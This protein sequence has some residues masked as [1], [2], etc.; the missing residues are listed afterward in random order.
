MGPVEI[1]LLA[2]AGLITSMLSA[3]VGMAG[4]MTLLAVMLLFLDPLVAVP[5]HGV[6]QLVSNGTRTAVHRRSLRPDILW[7]FAVLLVPMTWLG[8]DLAQSL[9]AGATRILIGSFV[10]IATWAPRLLRLGAGEAS[11]RVGTRFLAVGGVVGLLNPTIGA[12][13]PLMAPLFLGIGLDRFTLIGNKA[14]CQLMGHAIKIA[15]FGLAGFAYAEYAPL[16]G[17]LALSVVLGTWIGT[18]LLHRVTEGGFTLLYRGVLT[19]LA[20]QLV[21]RELF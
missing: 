12:T 5:L 18:R 6:V 19:L 20:V 13:G 7:R 8:L 16:L 9:P 2:L 17:V 4:G 10:L 11:E 1:G 14:A 21:V 15:L 3:V